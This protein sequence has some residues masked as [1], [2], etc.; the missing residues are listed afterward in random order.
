MVPV[1]LVLALIIAI[2]AVI[3]ALQ[4]TT[5]VAVTFLAWQ[6]E[7]SL[8]LVL[9]LAVAAGVLVGLFTLFP[10]N[11]RQRFQLSALRKKVEGVEKSLLELRAKE[12]ERL[13][14]EKEKAL[15]GQQMDKPLSTAEK[16]REGAPNLDASIG[17]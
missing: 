12:E 3:F 17:R 7:Q 10:S 6:F 5:L 16:M 14:A 2:L 8:A 13:I 15:A 9:L 1:L 11:I 4:N